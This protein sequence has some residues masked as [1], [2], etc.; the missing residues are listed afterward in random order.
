MADAQAISAEF[1]FESKFVDVRGSRMHYIDEG[2]GE[3]VLFLHGNPTSSYLWRNII[4]HVSPH[5]RCIAPD[6]IGFGKSDKP[7]I[8]YRF[9][10][11]VPYVEGFIEELG[12]KNVTLVLHDWGSGLGFHYAMR[13]EDNIRGIAFMEALIKPERWADFPPDFRRGFKMFRTPGVGW[14]M[15]VAMNAFV[16]K[17]LPDAIAGELSEEAKQHYA[18][19]FP[20]W[21]SRKPVRVW[22]NEVPIEGKPADVVAAVSEYSERLTKSELPKLMFTATPGGIIR[23][24]RAAWAQANMKN[25]ETVDIGPGIHFLQEDN[26][27]LIGTELARWYSTI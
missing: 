24:E 10:D 2:S 17:L 26:P 3:P 12:L 13:H 1:P 5:A 21:K 22:P 6:L 9:F 23:E 20:T 14:V 16:K 27:E 18:E 15:I 4:P 25:L 7:D 11:H 8:G 19:P